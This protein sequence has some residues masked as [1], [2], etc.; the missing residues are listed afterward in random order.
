MD[1]KR[2]FLEELIK[3]NAEK[4]ILVFVRTKIR[5]ERVKKAMERVEIVS[6]TIHSDKE[7]K[8][9]ERTM[10]S[11]RHGNLK[12]LIATD[13]SARGI[14]I[15]NVELVINYDLPES[16]ENYVHRVGRTGRGMQK[17]EAVTFCSNEEK[18]VLDSIEKNLEKPI[19]RIEITKG[20]YQFT[21]DSTEE[22]TDD[23]QSLLKEAE[24]AES[25]HKKRKK[26]KK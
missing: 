14:D 11:F 23:W 19:R 1:D 15:P 22:K 25:K 10:D 2:F 3:S 16:I 21:L 18:E 26:K 17:G 8:E 7:Q 20:E 5:A 4:K 24:E 9:R 12:V 6:D 13:V